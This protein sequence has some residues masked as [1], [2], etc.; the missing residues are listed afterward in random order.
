MS[1]SD[2]DRRVFASG[3]FIF[4]FIGLIIAFSALVVAAA[5]Y[6]RSDDAKA[7]VQKVATAGVVPSTTKVTLQEFRIVPHPSVVKAGKVTFDVTNTGAATH[8]MVLVRAPSIASLPRVTTATAERAVGDVDEEAIA[9]AD[10]MGETGDVKPHAHVTK[11][12]TLQPGTYVMFCNIDDTS[13]DGTVTNHFQHGM[14]AMLV[15]V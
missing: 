14:S 15:A 13:S 11:T 7:A 9:P 8:E 6:S 1:T 3:A 12:F 5:A 4:S 10:T 2:S